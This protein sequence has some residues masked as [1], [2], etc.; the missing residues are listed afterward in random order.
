[1]NSL[2]LTISKTNST[3]WSKSVIDLTNNIVIFEYSGISLFDESE[4]YFDR[5]V[6]NAKLCYPNITEVERFI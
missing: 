1:M 6:S 4:E 3:T 5:V 2:K